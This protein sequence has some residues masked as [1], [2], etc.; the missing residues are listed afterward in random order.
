MNH[1]VYSIVFLSSTA[2]SFTTGNSH[3]SEPNRG[4]TIMVPSLFFTGLENEHNDGFP[5]DDNQA[6]LMIVRPEALVSE[7]IEYQEDIHYP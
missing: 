7:L 5:R 1:V 3:P 6:T 2:S 4:I